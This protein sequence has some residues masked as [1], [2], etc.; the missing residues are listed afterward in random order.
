[1][2][3]LEASS[4]VHDRMSGVGARSS[5]LTCF[6]TREAA[7]QVRQTISFSARALQRREFGSSGDTRQ[8]GYLMMSFAILYRALSNIIVKFADML[9]NARVVGPGIL[10]SLTLFY[11]TAQ[12]LTPDIL[13]VCLLKCT[14]CFRAGS[15]EGC[16]FFGDVRF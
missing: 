16:N 7:M 6:S 4:T 14:R 1:M 5:L 9:E 8:G 13:N 10:S 2:C 15:F 12:A 11:N 3:M